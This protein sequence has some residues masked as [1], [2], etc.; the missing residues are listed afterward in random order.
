MAMT[1]RKRAQ[2][3]VAG[4]VSGDFLTACWRKMGRAR[5]DE[6]KAMREKVILIEM[7]TVLMMTMMIWAGEMAKGLSLVIRGWY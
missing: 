4:M 2:I 7:K 1:L 5:A 6:M 3:E